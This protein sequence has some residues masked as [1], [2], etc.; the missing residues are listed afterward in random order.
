MNLS[1]QVTIIIEQLDNNDYPYRTFIAHCRA[2]ELE[3]KLAS[4]AR[5]YNMDHTRV[6]HNGEQ[7]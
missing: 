7:S 5:A 2:D 1:R 4:I 6:T 3:Q